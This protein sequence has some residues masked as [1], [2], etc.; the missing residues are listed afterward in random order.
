MSPPEPQTERKAILLVEDNIKEARLM[1]EVLQENSQGHHLQ[2]AH[3]AEEAIRILLRKPPHHVLPRPDLVLLDI[4]LP[5]R[6]G[7]ELLNA[8]K[9]HPELKS[10]PV[11]MLSSSQA[12]CDVAAS[13]AGHAN[14]Y[15]VKPRTY[16]GLVKLMEQTLS[17]WLRLNHLPRALG[18]A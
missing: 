2:V 6:N 15:L 18:A 10:T 3:D 11:I 12:D 1:R 7:I 4:N 16:D 13:Y 17:Y 5:C 8:I 14:G 9:R